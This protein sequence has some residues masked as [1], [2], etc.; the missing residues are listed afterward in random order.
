MPWITLVHGGSQHS[1]L[2]SAQVDA[3]TADSV[4]HTINHDRNGAGTPT[5]IVKLDTTLHEARLFHP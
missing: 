2:F 3:Y 5:V 4:L 1:G